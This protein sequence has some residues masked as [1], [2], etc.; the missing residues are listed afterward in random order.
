MWHDINCL[1]NR[2]TILEQN[3]RKKFVNKKS[4]YFKGN[5]K[6]MIKVSINISSYWYK[7]INSRI[8]IVI[9]FS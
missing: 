7:Y 3:Y 6:T 2:K 9:N 5:K 1:V 8:P 4:D